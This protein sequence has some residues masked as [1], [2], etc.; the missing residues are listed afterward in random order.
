M[1]ERQRNHHLPPKLRIA[2]SKNINW[3]FSAYYRCYLSWTGPKTFL[4]QQD[5]TYDSHHTKEEPWMAVTHKTTA[6]NALLRKLL[7]SISCFKNNIFLK[8]MRLNRINL[9]SFADSLFE[10]CTQ[11]STEHRRSDYKLLNTLLSFLK[12]ENKSKCNMFFKGGFRN[13]NKV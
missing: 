8:N 5:H 11:H 3:Y 13:K 1:K 4:F 7:M 12:N 10:I 2:L 9:D 6:S